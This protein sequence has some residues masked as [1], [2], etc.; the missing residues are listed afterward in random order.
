[1]PR[2]GSRNYETQKV[3]VVV[4]VAMIFFAHAGESGSRRNPRWPPPPARK[5]PFGAW[6][7]WPALLGIC[8]VFRG[9]GHC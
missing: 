6:W 8:R 3:V 4:V 2:E 7:E 5:D 9:V 1:M